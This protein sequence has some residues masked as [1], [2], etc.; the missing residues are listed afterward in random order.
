MSKWHD[1]FQPFL[2]KKK[3]MHNPGIEPSTFRITF[4]CVNHCTIWAADKFKSFYQKLFMEG[5][6]SS[7]I[8]DGDLSSK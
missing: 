4:G 3:I 2:H 8:Q 6:V 1:N 7:Q 5:K